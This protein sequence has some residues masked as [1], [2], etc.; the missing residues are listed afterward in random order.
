MRHP[1]AT[2]PPAIPRPRERTTTAS[3]A[4]NHAVAALTTMNR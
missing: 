3:S 1:N 2:G 4:K